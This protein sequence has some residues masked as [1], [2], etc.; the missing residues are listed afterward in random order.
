MEEN[1]SGKAANEKQLI[2]VEDDFN[3]QN[4]DFQ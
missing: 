3:D 4:T 2:K 1:L